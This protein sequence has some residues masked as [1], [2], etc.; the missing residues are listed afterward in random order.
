MKKLFLMLMSVLTL[1][2]GLAFASVAEPN[3]LR[4]VLNLPV[5]NKKETFG[6]YIFCYQNKDS[7]SE[8]SRIDLH[9]GDYYRHC[10]CKGG[11]ELEEIT[12]KIKDLKN[13]NQICQICDDYYAKYW[14]QRELKPEEKTGF[15]TISRY[16]ANGY[17]Q[18][19]YK[20][21]LKGDRTSKEV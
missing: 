14:K 7:K 8:F 20:G 5:F 11:G 13:D 17:E 3:T 2:Y 16:D 6:G 4:E 15:F 12:G 19:L 18:E 10:T 9:N 21:H 1:S